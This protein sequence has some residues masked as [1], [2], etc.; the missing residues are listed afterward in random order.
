M[1]QPLD[2][3]K[4]KNY[5]L[6]PIKTLFLTGAHTETNSTLEGDGAGG[7]RWGREGGGRTLFIFARCDI[8]IVCP[9]LSKTAV[10]LVV[11]VSQ[12]KTYCWLLFSFMFPSLAPGLVPQYSHVCTP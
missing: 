10:A 7:G 9:F 12:Y 1:K 3:L 6:S 4:N 5:F 2:S 11:C 8:S